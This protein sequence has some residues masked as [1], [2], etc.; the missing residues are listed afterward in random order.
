M[1]IGAIT[2]VLVAM[3]VPCA[4][5]SS[6][7]SLTVMREYVP[8]DLISEHVGIPDNLQTDAG[9][10][11]LLASMLEGSPTF[12]R[13]CLRLASEP[14]LVVRIHPFGSSW[15]RGARAL[16][17][18][19]RGASGGLT[20][21]I[22]LTRFDDEVELIAHEIEHVI[23]QLDDVDLSA[24]AERSDTGVHHTLAAEATFETSRA[25]QTGLRVAREVHETRKGD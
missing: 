9:S 17:H 15:T 16:T 11:V 6:R 8:A 5:Q 3:S 7:T 10:R 25:S 20:A 14:G 2:C 12:R 22:Y 19:V 1:N 18:L 21:E 13:Q 23:E 24:M 4:A